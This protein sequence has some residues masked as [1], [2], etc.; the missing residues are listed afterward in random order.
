MTGL[1]LTPDQVTLVQELIVATLIVGFTG[2][3]LV[4]VLGAGLR[5]DHPV[6]DV[7]VLDDEPADEECPSCGGSGVVD[8]FLDDWGREVLHDQACDRCGGTGRPEEAWL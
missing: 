3:A 8:V 5:D 4:S 1:V 7:L 6:P 2:I